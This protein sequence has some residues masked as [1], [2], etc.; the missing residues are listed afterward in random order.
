M[1]MPIKTV[2]LTV[3]ASIICASWAAGVEIPDSGLLLRESTPPPTLAPRQEPPRIQM[4]AEQKEQAPAGIKVRVSGFS[5]VGNKVFSSEQLSALLAPYVGK[6]L[7][8]NELNG[9]AAT[10]TKAYRDQGYFLAY[11][12]VPPQT[13]K[14]GTP[15]IIEVVEGTL[16]RVRVET[17]PGET[18]V[19]KSLLQ[20]FADRVPVNEPV[21]E[22]S[23]ISMVMRV[24]ELPNIS[25]RILLEPGVR[26]GT[27][28][29]RLEVTEGKSYGLS[30]DA[31]NYGNYSTGL[32]RVGG[33]LEL[34]SPF[35]LGDQFSLRAQTSTSGDTQAVHAGYSV[36]VNS[37]GTRVGLDYT[38]VVYQLGRSFEALRA[39]GDAHSFSLGIKQ[40]LLRS[41]NLILNATL[42]GEGKLLDDRIDSV[43]AKNQRHTAGWQAGLDGVEMDSLLRGGFTSF[44]LGYLGGHLG[45]DDAASL[46]NDQAAGGLGTD[47]GYTKIS[48]LLARTQALFER[49]S[50]YAGGYG[51]W[52]DKNLDSSEQISLGGPS[53]VRAWQP[54]DAS[55]DSGVVTS[56]E[57]RYAIDQLGVVPG[58]LQLSGFFDYGYAVLHNDPAPGGN[59]ET[60][61]LTGAGF[62]VSW[63]DASSFSVRTTVAWKISGETRPRDTPMV[64]FQALTRF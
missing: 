50:L 29:A 52:A 13:V 1:P 20:G 9:A 58:S 46:A 6:D 64:Y 63:F 3:A 28:A 57:L 32:Y 19:P 38:Y 18:R 51:Q 21:Q 53:A 34:Y 56:A 33:G 12:F 37:Y 35:R 2:L 55:G 22:G 54:D 14:T 60:R 48:M 10:I 43:G 8:L 36:P 11:A 26:P 40:P 59:E 24:N 30:L 47:G 45:I 44:S 61:N 5:F 4:P 7:N 15:V 25:S 39:N 41:R 17:I 23:L 62:G 42:A 27:T 31:D 16:E 49:F